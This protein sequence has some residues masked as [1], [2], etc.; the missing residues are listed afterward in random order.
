MGCVRYGLPR[1]LPLLSE[2]GIP[3]S[4]FCTNFI[5]EKYVGLAAALKSFGH[6]LG[7]HG[8]CHEYLAGHS[9]QEQ[10]GGIAEMLAGKE[11]RQSKSRVSGANFIGRI[12]SAT[13]EAI[14]GNG[15]KY[16]VFPLKNTRKFY[17]VYSPP[18][19][20]GADSGN[21]ALVPIQA[22]TYGKTWLQVKAQ[23][24]NT[25]YAAGRAER[26]GR[27]GSDSVHLTVLLHPFHDGA[28]ENLTR[29]RLLLDYF[30]EN[31][32]QPRRIDEVVQS[33][34][35]SANAGAKQKTGGLISF[36]VSPV[37]SRPAALVQ[38]LQNN[39]A[40]AKCLK[41]PASALKIV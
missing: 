32:F 2:R 10:R 3:A 9:L 28:L 5:L 34:N 4:F 11:I 41:R 21:V 23:I 39:F 15:L 31:G 18:L 20:V 37:K 33:A 22:E 12:D 26:F 1:I 38:R 14:A 16:F 27:D 7:V 25:L 17:S 8:L 40:V 30:D 6:E 13:V 29:L 35:A 19:A 24:N 36:R